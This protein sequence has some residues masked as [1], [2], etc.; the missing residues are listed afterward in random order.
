MK[1]RRAL[2]LAVILALALP[3]SAATAEDSQT[4]TAPRVDLRWSQTFPARQE[5]G[6]VAVAPGGYVLLSP[7]H[8]SRGLHIARYN[9]RGHEM[10][11]QGW[12]GRHHRA[13]KSVMG[14]ATAVSARHNAVLIA[15]HATC[16]YQGEESGALGPA[17]VRKYTLR[18]QLRWTR[19]IGACPRRTAD[20]RVPP[21]SV[22]GLDALGNQVAVSY[23]HGYSGDCCVHHRKG[24]VALLGLNGATAWR[25]ML[26]FPLPRVKE[27]VTNDVALSSHSVTVSGAVMCGSHGS[28]AYLVNLSRFSGSTSWRHVNNGRSESEAAEATNDEY[29]DLDA[30]GDVVFAAGA[31]DIPFEGGRSRAILERWSVS[32]ERAWHVR[33][34]SG[35]APSVAALQDGSV[36]WSNPVWGRT[37]NSYVF[38]KQH[39]QGESAWKVAWKLPERDYPIGYA[40]AANR[41]VAFGAADIIHDS[42][43]FLQTWCWHL[44]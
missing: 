5:P 40:F 39:P 18:G 7:R 13:V 16:R 15:G 43:D 26:D 37:A 34:G 38:G 41:H 8:Y 14:E 6:G 19:W 3:V 22:S 30:V 17:F 42:R 28:D 36:L 44:R 20:R 24:H 10:W 12:I 2:L 23:T 35:A 4:A 25:T 31:L 9:R 33:T 21:L 11:D 32:G 27:V 29:S 1:T